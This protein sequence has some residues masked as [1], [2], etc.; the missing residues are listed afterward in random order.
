MQPGEYYVTVSSPS[1]KNTFRTTITVIPPQTPAPSET[2]VTSVGTLPGTVPG[3][4]PPGTSSGTGTLSVSSTPDGAPVFLD[5]VSVGVTPI[6]LGSITPGNH[7]VEIK[8]PG[9]FAYSVQVTVKPAE[10]TSLSPTLVKNPL[11]LP[12]SPVTACAGLLIAGFLFVAF[13]AGRRDP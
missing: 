7:L 9:Y 12:V 2:P 10:T 13:S 11:S 6:T 5:S 4:V 3:Q 1:V 8:P